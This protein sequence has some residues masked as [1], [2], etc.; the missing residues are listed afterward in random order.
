MS[1]R[2]AEENWSIR[3]TQ[4]LAGGGTHGK[5][6]KESRQPL[7]EKINLTPSWQPAKKEG[8]QSYSHKKI[9]SVNN[10]RKLGSGFFPEPHWPTPWFQSYEKWSR[11]TQTHPNCWLK[12]LWNN[13]FAVFKKRGGPKREKKKQGAEG[14][15]YL[16]VFFFFFFNMKS[17]KLDHL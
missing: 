1:E 17:R 14:S 15:S 12:E 3:E 10:P 2:E 16:I 4:S 6:Q 11:A 9:D 13:K 5:C 7:G 8:S